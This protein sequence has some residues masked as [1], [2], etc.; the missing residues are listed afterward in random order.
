MSSMPLYLALAADVVGS[1]TRTD[2]R[3]LQQALLRAIQREN[4]RL[5]RA[6]VAAPLALS[7]GDQLQILLRHP[8]LAAD[9]IRSLAD[10]PDLAGPFPL[11]RFGLGYGGLSTGPLPAAPAQASSPGSLDGPCFHRAQSALSAAKAEG[12]WVRTSGLP[13]VLEAGLHGLFDLL[14]VVRGGWSAKQAQASRHMRGLATQRELAA[15]LGLSPS[16][17]SERLKSAHH[18]ALLAGERAADALLATLPGDL[19]RG[20][21]GPSKAAPAGTRPA[22]RRPRRV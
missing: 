18:N 20:S 10:D 8:L 3:R 11:L 9:L 15:R 17:V 1:R 4:Q 2:R 22:A 16:V 7:S 12:A 5:P 14:A 19:P 21:S 13:E 6:G